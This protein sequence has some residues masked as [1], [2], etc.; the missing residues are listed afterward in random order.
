MGDASARRLDARGYLLFVRFTET[1]EKYSNAHFPRRELISSQTDPA[2]RQ[3]EHALSRV[4]SHLTRRRLQS[5]HATLARP[6]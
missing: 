5:L 1:T 2:D 4:R 6:F 3:F